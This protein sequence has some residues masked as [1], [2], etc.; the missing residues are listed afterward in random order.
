MK[1]IALHTPAGRWILA[2]TILATGMA[3]LD[4]TIIF[5]VLPTLQHVFAASINSIQWVVNSYMLLLASLLMV[6]GALGDRFGRRRIY[7][8]GIV[9]FMIASVLCGL[10]ESI[11]QLIIYRA[12]Q[13]LGAALMIPGSLAIINA[14]FDEKERGQAIGLWSGLTGAI[15]AAGPPI[16]GWLI[17]HATWQ[18][19][20]Y[21]NLIIGVLALAIIYKTV[22]E[23]KSQFKRSFDWWGTGWLI[24]ALF[25]LAYSLI[26]GPIIGWPDLS[27]IMSLAIGLVASVAFYL[28][29]RYGHQPLVPAELFKDRTVIGANLLTLTQYCA[30]NGIFF[31][32]ALNLQQVQH[33]SP[34][35]ASFQFLP[36]TLMILL[37]AG[38]GGK[39]GDQ[40]GNQIPL[41]IGPI[42]TAV[43]MVALMIPGAG[44]DWYSFIPGLL[45]LGAGMVLV[46]APGTKAALM[47][48]PD[49]SGAASG[50]NNAVARIAALLSICLTGIIMVAVFSSD[51]QARIGNLALSQ[52]QLTSL[53]S[54]QTRLAGLTI[55][56]DL[57][58]ELSKEVNHAIELAF[59]KG[60]RATLSLNIILM[61][62]S[63]IIA[64][65]L[66]KKSARPI[67][68]G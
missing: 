30:L 18:W 62:A 48:D 59:I 24:F 8:L 6:G 33:F 1:S 58:P 20:F 25:G 66:L 60:Y 3:F 65:A 11:D 41:M 57:G 55:P 61:I 14:T 31:I 12:F 13:G 40:I 47:V 16:G 46:A 28:S 4:G 53:I 5:L 45:L 54:Q 15:L 43:A 35:I 34:D 21:I 64:Y 29:Q 37:F 17:E 27:I 7:A 51:F 22:P 63:S 19:I 23:S 42:I 36:F 50:F 68:R 49:H 52:V 56:G 2:G 67:E 9:I 44:A 32:L 26:Q 10:A 39:L 38:W